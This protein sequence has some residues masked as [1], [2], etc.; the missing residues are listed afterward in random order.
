MEPLTMART[1]ANPP[2]QSFG[3]ENDLSLRVRAID[4]ALDLEAEILRL[5]KD[6]NAVIL[7]H[8]Y[9]DADIQDLADHVGDSLALAQAAAATDADELKTCVIRQ[10]S[11]VGR[12]RIRTDTRRDLGHSIMESPPG[13][14][15]RECRF[16][17]HFVRR[18]FPSVRIASPSTAG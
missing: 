11:N 14:P 7:A 13:R 15:S 8:Y 9:Q 12:Q 2:M 5:K 3:Q 4:P 1:D 10:C 18:H 6:L 17:R 16:R